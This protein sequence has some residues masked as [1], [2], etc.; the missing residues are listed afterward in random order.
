MRYDFE[1]DIRKAKSNLDKHELSF[2]RA[3]TIFRDPNI[4][5]IP[6]EEHSEFEERW[7]TIGL[8]ESGI[9]LVVSHIFKDLDATACKIRIISAR[10]ATKAEEEQYEEG[11]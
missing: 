5:S 2:E 4:L 8:D 6:D 1:W 7:I 3:A 9:L 11:I 10:K